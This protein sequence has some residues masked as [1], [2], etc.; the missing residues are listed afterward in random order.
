MRTLL[1]DLRFAFRTLGKQPG[2]TL[3]ATLTLA[4][5]IGVNTSIFSM[6]S[7]F[8]LQPPSGR[9]PDRIAVISSVNPAPAFQADA[10]PVSRPNYLAWRTA[11][12]VFS[13][14]AASES[15]SVNLSSQGAPE[16]FASD[17]VTPNYFDVLGVAPAF[18]RTFAMGDDQPG[19][20]HVV[21][22]SH[23]L[24][25]RRFGSD[26]SIIGRTVR[27]NRE[28]YTVIGV[29]PAD[30]HLLGFVAQLWTPLAIDAANQ[31][32]ALRKDRSLTVFARFKPGCN[33]AQARAEFA[34]FARRTQGDFAQTEK[35]W[36]VTV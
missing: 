15:R 26:A 12:N 20:D 7:A 18:G 27:L 3:V 36:T 5:G 11:N 31:N 22:L 25:E 30:F 9:E 23:G 16:A 35:G 19:R 2:F 34:A 21:I 14:M 17:A 33:L 24:W 10:F 29:T 1:Q 4:L 6:V 13:D 8:L 32:E 28:N